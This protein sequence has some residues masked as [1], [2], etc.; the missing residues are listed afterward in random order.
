MNPNPSAFQRDGNYV[1]IVNLGLM[2]SKAITYSA[3]TTGAVGVTTLFTVTGV[4]AMRV[5]AIASGVNLT[6]SGSIEVGVSGNA[7]AVIAQTAATAINVGQFWS[8]TSP[9]TVQVLPSLQTVGSDVIQTISTATVTAGTLTY[10]CLWTP[11]SPDGN[12]TTA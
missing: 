3:L 4:V 6:G 12:V 9:A 11:V 2:S 8:T 1:P 5:F 7:A 10:Y